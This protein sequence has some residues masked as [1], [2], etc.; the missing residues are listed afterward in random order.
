MAGITPRLSRAIARA[1]GA[2]FVLGL[3]HA[4]LGRPDYQLALSQHAAYCRAL[5][6]CGLTLTR[7]EPDERFPDSTFV[8]DTAVI[9]PSHDETHDSEKRK[10]IITRPGAA[11][12][13]GEERIIKQTLTQLGLEIFEIAPPGTV[14]GGD[15]CET[16]DHFFIGISERTNE[17]GA[18]QFADLLS[19]FGYT[20]TLVD[21]RGSDTILHLKS[22]LAYLG[23]NRL[24]VIDALATD[25]ALRGYELVHVGSDD[26]YAANCLRVNDYLLV[27]A[28][29]PRF[30]QSLQG[31]GFETIALRMSEFQK[32]DG[33]LSCLSLR[34]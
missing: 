33:G 27:A 19:S 24:V 5:G 25:S 21:V 26:E 22:G 2:S 14:D 13:R 1:P 3:T 17:A 18:G 29:F 4:N 20:S 31:L 7:L 8:E 23:N 16:D 12:R 28:G 10:A 15:I 11:S 34:F 32:L 6:N 9:I 30:E